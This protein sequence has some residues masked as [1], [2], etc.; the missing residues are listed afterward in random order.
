MKT[1]TRVRRRVTHKPQ[2]M[3]SRHSKTTSQTLASVPPSQRAMVLQL[4]RRYGNQAVQ[5]MLNAN[6]G[7]AAHGTVQP[8]FGM[9][10]AVSNLAGDAASTMGMPGPQ[11]AFEAALALAGVPAEPVMNFINQSGDAA[12]LI[13]S[14]PIG[15][16]NNLSRAVGEGFMQFTGN[17]TKHLQQGILMWMF[18][19]LDEAGLEVPDKFDL[20]GLFYV[21]IQVLE[22]TWEKIK[23][24]LAARMGGAA[25]AALDRTLEYYLRASSSLDM[26][27]DALKGGL[28]AFLT[29][30][31]EKLF[32]DLMPKIQ[33]AAGKMLTYFNPVGSLVEAIK[34][35][36][37]VVVW[38]ADSAK[39]IAGLAGTIIGSVSDIALGNVKE[40]GKKIAMTLA[41]AG[42][43]AVEFLLREFENVTDSLEYLEEIMGEFQED[44]H[45]AIVSVI[46]NMN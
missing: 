16:V 22:I 12:S 33:G 29:N 25:G 28:T 11:Q 14:D 45:D 13:F 40:V 26:I 27:W 31:Q 46:A 41:L 20:K 37:K 6:K 24:K 38:L 19:S 5:R 7:N 4:Q 30:L 17:M 1:R 18:E 43:R 10:A 2:K 21:I 44:L 15:F 3:G 34:V 32:E 35:I 9:P 42:G 23:R 39:D 8:F 36:Y